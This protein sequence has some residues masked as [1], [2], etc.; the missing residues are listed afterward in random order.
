MY[1]HDILHNL[2][3]W[4]I[5]WIDW[6]ICL[7]MEG[8]PNWVNNIVDAPILVDG[9]KDEFYK[10][11]MFYFIAHFSKFIPPGSVRI[12]SSLFNNLSDYSINLLNKVDHVAFVTPR[13]D[14]IIVLINPNEEIIEL[15]IKDIVE[16]REMK[17]ELEPNSI[18]TAIWN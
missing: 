14:K 7:N 8:G 15:N 16:D 2:R 11:P 17:I 5:G 6:N 1:G 13:G 10:Q 18:M 9:E 4:A 12:N 3:N